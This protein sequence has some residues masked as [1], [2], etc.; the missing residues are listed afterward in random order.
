VVASGACAGPGVALD[1]VPENPTLAPGETALVRG[2]VTYNGVNVGA[3]ET[4]TFIS[5]NSAWVT[6]A[7]SGV[8][9]GSGIV[10]VLITG[11]SSPVGCS[12]LGAGATSV[13]ITATYQGASG[14]ASIAPV[15][16]I[17]LVGVLA[18]AVLFGLAPVRRRVRAKRP[19]T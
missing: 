3:G 4:V 7:P 8:T 19:S 6:V 16:A 5:S 12:L 1:I 18:L 15:P 11:V 17:S 9:D 10:E 2:T 14:F 13:M